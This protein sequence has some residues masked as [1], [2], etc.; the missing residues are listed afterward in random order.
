MSETPAD[1]GAKAKA[2]AAEKKAKAEAGAGAAEAGSA[3]D[4]R[5]RS[6]RYGFSSSNWR[7]WRSTRSSAWSV[8]TSRFSMTKLPTRPK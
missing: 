1:K 5:Q 7:A 4:A 6:T 8:V 3:V 2:A